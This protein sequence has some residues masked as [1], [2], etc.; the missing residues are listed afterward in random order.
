MINEHAPIFESCKPY[1]LEEASF[2]GF[3]TETS[4]VQNQTAVVFRQLMIWR[5]DDEAYKN[6]PVYD[7][8]IYPR[9]YFTAFDPSRP[10]VKWAAVKRKEKDTNASLKPY[11][12]PRGSYLCFTHTERVSPSFF[13]ELYNTWLPQSPYE[14]DDRPHFDKMWPDPTNRGAVVKEEIYIPIK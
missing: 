14:L 2:L 1:L 11:V 5:K 3:S 7:I 8:K 12:V 10:F 9:D 6:M 13:Q 4:L